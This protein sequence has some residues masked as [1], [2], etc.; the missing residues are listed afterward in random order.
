MNYSNITLQDDNITRIAY[1]PVY[2]LPDHKVINDNSS[3]LAKEVLA[4]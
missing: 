2:I 1:L 3:N 4:S